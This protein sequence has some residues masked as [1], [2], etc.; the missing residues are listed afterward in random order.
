MFSRL[1]P[2][3][4]S[5]IHINIFQIAVRIPVFHFIYSLFILIFSRLL[6]GFLPTNYL[7]S[8][9]ILRIPRLV[10]TN[11][12]SLSIL[13]FSRLVGGFLTTNLLFSFHIIKSPLVGGFLATSYFYLLSIHIN[14]SAIAVLIHVFHLVYSLIH[15]KNSAIGRRIARYISVFSIFVTPLFITIPQTPS[16]IDFNQNPHR[17]LCTEN[18]KHI[19]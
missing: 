18:L 14:V 9:S 1:V 2:T 17:I 16:R 7:L 6:C 10:P 11:L 5:L 12:L 19:T 15:I 4:L 3:N 8:L 13:I